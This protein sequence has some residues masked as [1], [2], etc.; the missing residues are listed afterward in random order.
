MTGAFMR[1]LLKVLMLAS[2][3]GLAC[4]ANASGRTINVCFPDDPFPPVS[5]PGAEWPGQY[6]VRVIVES[7]GDKATFNPVPWRRCVELVRARRYDA[8]LGAS[9]NPSFF[10]FMRFPT[11]D[12][13]PDP[14]RAIGKTSLIVVRQTGTTATW[15]GEKFD[16]LDGAVIYNSGMVI[17]KDKLARLGVPGYDGGKT[18]QQQLEM[19]LVKRAALA[20]IPKGL[21][22]GLVNRPK[23]K[24]K[25]EALP[26]PFVAI[27]AYFAV[28]RSVYDADQAYFDGIWAEIAVRRAATDWNKTEKRLL[29]R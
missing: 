7:R 2:V 20:V 17:V 19:L 5:T 13:K 26:V 22:D 24:S 14:D 3:L 28:N 21:F 23:F 4:R 11:K 29:G 16:Q 6:L 8:A 10:D 15:N 27:T 12:G 9:A 1:S 18:G 25:F